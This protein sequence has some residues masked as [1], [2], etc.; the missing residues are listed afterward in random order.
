MGHPEKRNGPCPNRR[1]QDNGTG[2]RGD[3]GQLPLRQVPIRQPRFGIIVAAGQGRRFGGLK[4]FALVQG[5]PLIQFSLRAFELCPDVTG[6]VLVVNRSKLSEARALVKTLRL[7]K[8]LALVAGGSERQESVANGLACLPESGFVAIHDG[9]RP[10]VTPRMLS[11]GFKVCQRHQ[12]AAYGT[13]VTDTLKLVRNGWLIRTI[14]R[15]GV[16]AIQ[17]PQFFSLPLLRRAMVSAPK[18][19]DECALVERLG[20][21]PRLLLSPGINLKV[22]TRADLRLCETLL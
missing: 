21:R 3:E 4:Q 13:F 7:R 20:I 5:K 11:Y 15:N 2:A 19:T 10:F 16:V 17:T 12:A 18:A 1:R 6:Y 14:D 8:V 9:V 22:T